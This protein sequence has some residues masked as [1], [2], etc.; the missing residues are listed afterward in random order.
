MLAVPFCEVRKRTLPMNIVFGDRQTS[1]RTSVAC[2]LALLMAGS[3]AACTSAGAHP[4][5]PQRAS[6]LVRTIR[7][8]QSPFAV[9]DDPRS[10]RV[11]V[12]NG[13]DSNAINDGSGLLSLSSVSVLDAATGSLVHTVPFSGYVSRV[14]TVDARTCRVWLIKRSLTANSP[15]TLLVLDGTTGMLLRT[16]PVGSDPNAIGIDPYARHV[17]VSGDRNVHILDETTGALLDTVPGAGPPFMVLVDARH[18][19]VRLLSGTE[20]VVLDETTGAVLS[21]VSVPTQ[22]N[23]GPAAF[24]VDERVGHIIV[25]L[26][27]ESTRGE[28]V[29][30]VALATGRLLHCSQSSYIDYMGGAPMAVDTVTGRVF[31]VSTSHSSNPGPVI[32]NVLDTHTGRRVRADTLSISSTR[33][34]LAVDDRASRV[35]VVNE[36]PFTSG[37]MPGRLTTLDA[38]TGQIVHTETAGKGTWEANPAVAVDD[39]AGRVFVANTIDKT[40]SVFDA[41][42][43]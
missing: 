10:R 11:F 23:E 15:G 18:A 32:I 3:T 34:S 42:R 24:V 33:V 19:R 7:L 30:V 38:R 6:P 40:I 26:Y 25:D 14:V 27:D 31:A 37:I 29:C 22:G 9:I 16:I 39:S 28:R 41:R 43:L 36:D 2:F 4:T 5:A 1:Y 12:L 21:D 20:E 35:F 13:H 8:S 17:F